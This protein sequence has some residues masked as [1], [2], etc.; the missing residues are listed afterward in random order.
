ME[1]ATTTIRI[2]RSTKEKLNAIGQK[3]MTYDDIINDLIS[4]RKESS[5]ST[6]KILLLIEDYRDKVM[7]SCEEI[8]DE[9]EYNLPMVKE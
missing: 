1:T 6:K 2:K 9:I 4:S 5:Q 3:G 8:I 7:Y